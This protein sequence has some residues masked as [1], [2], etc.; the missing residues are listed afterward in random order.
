MVHED[1]HSDCTDDTC[2]HALL[3]RDMVYQHYSNNSA[4]LFEPILFRFDSLLAPCW[5]QGL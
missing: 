1:T 2:G 3:S 5:P 4:H